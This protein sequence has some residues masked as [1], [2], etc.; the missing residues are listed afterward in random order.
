MFGFKLFTLFSI[1]GVQNPF[2]FGGLFKRVF[3]HIDFQIPPY[4][5]LQVP[6]GKLFFADIRLRY[7][8][9]D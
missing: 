5:P 3:L 8:Y 2:C 1:L 4:P 6:A 9:F 7:L